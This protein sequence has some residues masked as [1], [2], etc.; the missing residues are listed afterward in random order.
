MSRLFDEKTRF[1]SLSTPLSDL[2]G[3]ADEKTKEDGHVIT[4]AHFSCENC[5]SHLVYSPTS[6]DLLCRNCGHHYPVNTSLE[7]IH[8]YDFKEAVNELAR[9]RH[10]SYA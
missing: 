10:L 1:T 4:Q 8:E 3:E 6:Q 9:L 7:P 2:K 5:G